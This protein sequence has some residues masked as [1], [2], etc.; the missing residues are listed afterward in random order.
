MAYLED[1]MGCSILCQVVILP[2]VRMVDNEPT[3]KFDEVVSAL[4]SAKVEYIV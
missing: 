3:L 2:E 1:I 4:A